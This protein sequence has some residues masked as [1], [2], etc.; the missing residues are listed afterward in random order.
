VS[1]R[2]RFRDYREQLIAAAILG[3]PLAAITWILDTVSGALTA[4]PWHVLW[5]MGPLAVAAWIAWRQVM[6]RGALRV[7]GAMLVFLGCYL[8]VFSF[9]VASDLLVWKRS[10]VA[11]D[12]AQLARNWLLPARWGDWRYRFARPAPPPDRLVV[13]TIQKPDTAATPE[14]LRFDV[15]RL[16]QIA[17][18]N[19]ASGIAF[20]FY[21]GQKPSNVDAFLC[22]VVKN[23]GIPVIAGQRV[24]KGQAGRMF[25]ERYA[26]AIEP[27]FPDERRGHLIAYADA[28]GV[29]R[30]VVL[31]ISGIADS[32]SLSLR[33]ASL[34]DPDRPLPPGNL[35]RF[36]ESRDTFPSLPSETLAGLPA[37]ELGGVLH[38]RW[39][40]VGERSPA[41]MFHTPFGDRLGVEVH[42]AAIGA[43]LGGAWIE[44][45]PWWS[46]FFIMVVACYL[47]AALTAQGASRQKLL[48]VAFASSILVVGG[49]ALAIRFW[50]VW[51]DVIYPVVAV[52]LLLGLLLVLRR[53]LGGA[54]LRAS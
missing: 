42:A 13:I 32:T 19:G 54:G 51:L 16:V 38:G 35:L 15:A 21:F 7:R 9:A 45:A 53:R 8:A 44:R 39:V 18:Q 43:L 50:Q 36:V 40:L 4:Q 24:V 22:T 52:W 29:I 46:G 6:K 28:D 10:T 20:D 3:L 48:L 5:F 11:V 27:C 2:T 14:E 30:Q 26:P 12:Q 33:V 17:A 47:I 25:A 41:E 37:G 34:L 1:W 49:A 31:R 23:A